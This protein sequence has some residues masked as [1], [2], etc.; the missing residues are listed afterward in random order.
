LGLAALLQFSV[1]RPGIGPVAGAVLLLLAVMSSGVGLIVLVTAAVWLLLRRGLPAA[2][3]G[4]LPAALAF[5]VWYLVYGRDYE[6][7]MLGGW[8]YLGIPRAVWQGATT[9]LENASGVPDSGA[10]LLAVL[11]AAPLL[12]RDLPPGARD[13]AW[14]GQVGALTQLVLSTI[15]GGPEGYPPVTESRYAYIVLVLLTPSLTVVALGFRRVAP[16]LPR[17][18]LLVLGC[19][20]AA[21]YLVNAMFL[22]R[23]QATVFVDVSS[24][25]RDR[26]VGTVAATKAG[27]RV[28]TP[29]P[30]G[31]SARMDVRLM[32]SPRIT[33]TLPKEAADK[34]QRIDAESEFF[35][36]VSPDTFGLFAP[37]IALSDSFSQ[38]L[39]PGEGCATFTTVTDRPKIAVD[40]GDGVE[41]AVQGPSKQLTTRLER[42]TVISASRVWKVP[43][44]IPIHIATTAL[45]ARLVANF[46]GAGSYT[47]CKH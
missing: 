40:T 16:R 2:L 20:L 26:V 36:G 31:L 29:H 5:A 25:H 24:V 37:R 11:V 15:G 43:S 7:A 21:S 30:S 13:L 34:Q 33:E 22:Q 3:V 44:G 42:G 4:T 28:L 45:D 19:V 39:F 35:V 46:D 18:A 23:Q 10:V 47:I 8:G 9:A 6:R 17:R 12:L 32:T 1:D 14:A 27:E 41:I 38:P